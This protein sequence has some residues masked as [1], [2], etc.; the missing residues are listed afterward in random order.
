MESCRIW[1]SE[2]ALCAVRVNLGARSSSVQQV[3]QSIFSVRDV[4]MKGCMC[5][6]CVCACVYAYI[7]IYIYIYIYYMMCVR[8]FY[9]YAI[10]FI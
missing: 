9:A 7:Y 6:V 3:S 5:D 4:C 2:D 10:V 1:R 8:V